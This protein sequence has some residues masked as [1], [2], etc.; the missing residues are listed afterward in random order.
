MLNNFYIQ[1]YCKIK[2]DSLILDGKVLSLAKNNSL[3]DFLKS[4]YLEAEIDYPKFFKMDEL[5][6]LAFLATELI[7]KKYPIDKIS[8]NRRSIILSNSSSTVETDRKYYESIE[9]SQNYFPSP[10][11]FVYTL[12]NITIGEIA[13]RN[14]I[15]GEN[16][17]FVSKYFDSTFICQYINILLKNNKVDCLVT[18][19]VEFNNEQYDCF[20]CLIGKDKNQ[21]SIAYSKENIDS[22]YK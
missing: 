4:I 12:P 18:G 15:K 20:I 19:W 16:T 22:L 9:D 5:C 13:I 14:K 3:T 8:E 21:H 7:V 11:I 17:F 10:S 6:K 2:N 1:S